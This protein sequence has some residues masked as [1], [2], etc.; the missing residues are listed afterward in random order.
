[1]QQNCSS[2]SL[3]TVF[4]N[5]LKSLTFYNIFDAE[6]PLL[7]FGAKIQIFESMLYQHF[8]FRIF[9]NTVFEIHAKNVSFQFDVKIWKF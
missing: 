5:P 3:I 6:K 8:G 2:G 1:M 4:E 9:Q 7:F